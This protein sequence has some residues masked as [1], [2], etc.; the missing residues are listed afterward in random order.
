MLRGYRDLLST[1]AMVTE[2]VGIALIHAT[3]S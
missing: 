2:V 3:A 1:A